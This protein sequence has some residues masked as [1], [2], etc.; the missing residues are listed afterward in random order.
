MLRI[1]FVLA[2]LAVVGAGCG[3]AARPQKAADRGIP[4]A[5]ARGWAQQA[6]AVAAAASAG[7]DCGARR[8]ADALRDQ[9]VATK[10]R[11]PVRLRSSLLTG[12]KTLANRTT[13]PPPPTKKTPPAPPDKHPKHP[14]HDDHGHHKH[15]GPDGGAG[16]DR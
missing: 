11:V 12:V 10:G 5:L 1:V 15:H 2:L 6:A 9:V 14:K 7:D 13:C 16:N 4:R 8:L 3:G